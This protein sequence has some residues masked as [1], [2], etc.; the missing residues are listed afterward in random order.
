MSKN[1][2]NNRSRKVMVTDTFQVKRINHVRDLCAKHKPP[3]DK[4]TFI[5]EVG[6]AAKI[7][8]PTLEKAYNGS[9]E[10]DYDVIEKIAWFFE[11]DTNE[12]LESKF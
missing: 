9:T 12:V 8:R 7:S 4:K 6:Y 10:L 11:V 2:S 5:E 3:M 1:E